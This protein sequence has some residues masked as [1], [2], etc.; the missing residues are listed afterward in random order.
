FKIELSN[1]D[2]INVED[3]LSDILSEYNYVSNNFW[4]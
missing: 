3:S 2:I 4:T 1:D